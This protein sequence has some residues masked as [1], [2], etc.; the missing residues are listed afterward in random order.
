[1][2]GGILT[3]KYNNG[4]PEGSRYEKNPDLKRVLNKYLSDEVKDANIAKLK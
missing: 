1:L 4:I 3:G 2:A